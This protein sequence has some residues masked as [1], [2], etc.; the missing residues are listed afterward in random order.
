M[1]GRVGRGFAVIE[2]TV[3]GKKTLHTG[4]NVVEGEL[5]T[6]SLLGWVSHKLINQRRGK[7]EEED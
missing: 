4:C 1:V 7:G 3:P 5:S 2:W 6:G